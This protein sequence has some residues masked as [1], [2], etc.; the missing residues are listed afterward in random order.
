MPR[1][2]GSARDRLFTAAAELIGEHGF[3]GTTVD[4]VVERAGVAKGTVYYHFKSK[5]ALFDALLTEH[6]GRMEAAFRTAVA[7]AEHPAD[8]LRA[9]VRTELDYIHENRAASKLLMSEVWRSDRVWQETLGPLRE[10]YVAVYHEVLDAGVA[11]GAFGDHLDTGLAASAL[12]GMVATAALDWLVFDPD[13][14]ARDVADAVEALALR[15]V[16]A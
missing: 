14:D 3:H 12:F 8:A 9:L 11:S 7:S 1:T 5:E 13:R 2:T 16:S 10:R 4:D 6:F 15:A